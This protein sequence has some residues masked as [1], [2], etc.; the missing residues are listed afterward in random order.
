LNSPLKK[1]KKRK[2]EKEKENTTPT[3]FIVKNIFAFY[4]S[5]T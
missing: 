3:I 5:Y 4:V 2:K 1:L